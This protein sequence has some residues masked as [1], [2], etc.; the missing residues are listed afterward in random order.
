MEDIWV[1]ALVAVVS[2]HFGLSLVAVNRLHDDSSTWILFMALCGWWPFF[3][4]ER[5]KVPAPQSAGKA[6]LGTFF[7]VLFFGAFH[8][9]L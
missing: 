4:L 2:V 7:A 1:F 9:G 8:L 5:F 6:T 3:P